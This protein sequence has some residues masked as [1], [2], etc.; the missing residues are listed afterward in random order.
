MG[1]KE[2]FSDLF[3]YLKAPWTVAG[4]IGLAEKLEQGSAKDTKRQLYMGTAASLPELYL[5]LDG[6]ACGCPLK[7]IA[8]GGL[9]ALT[10]ILTRNAMKEPFK[11]LENMKADYEMVG[12]MM[13]SNK[14]N[15]RKLFSDI[16]KMVEKNDGDYRGVFKASIASEDWM[17]RLAEAHAIKNG[18]K[19]K[20]D[21]IY[22]KHLEETEPEGSMKLAEAK[23][24][25]S[26]SSRKGSKL[27]DIADAM[28]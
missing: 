2:Y 12:E 24:Q 23:K 10:M 22:Y 9:T 4:T 15:Y 21:R 17:Y 1:I 19:K 6:L 14:H 3:N 27:D 25:V 7:I 13:E 11:D 18:E 26:V 16:G 28:N 8:G 5:T 20:Y